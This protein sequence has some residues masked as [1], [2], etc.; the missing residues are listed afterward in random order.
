MP[1][2]FFMELR[3]FPL[4]DSS[5]VVHSLRLAMLSKKAPYA[6]AVPYRTQLSEATEQVKVHRELASAVDS[7]DRLVS[8]AKPEATLLA[9]HSVVIGRSSSERQSGFHVKHSALL[10]NANS[11]AINHQHIRVSRQKL[12]RLFDGVDR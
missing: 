10:I 2:Y 6:V 3:D 9:N 7:A 5:K 11:I 4:T 1:P 12:N 8:R